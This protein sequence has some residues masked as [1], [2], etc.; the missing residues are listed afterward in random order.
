M[1]KKIGLLFL[2]I[3]YLFFRLFDLE[4]TLNFS[5][6]QGKFLDKTRQIYLSKQIVLIGPPTSIKLKDSREF[7]QGPLTYYLLLPVIALGGDPIYGSYELIFLNLIGLIL[8]F[9]TLE[10]I[11]NTKVA[12]LSGLI[13]ATYPDLVTYT[14]FIWNPN[15]LPFFSSVTLF[16]LEKA[17]NNKSQTI[18]LLIGIVL[19]LALQLH[20][21]V[22]VLI[23]IVLGFFL[24]KKENFYSFISLIAGICIGFFPILIFEVRH[25]FYNFRTVLLIFKSGTGK[26]FSTVPVYFLLVLTPYF[27]LLGGFLFNK[28]FSKTLIIGTGL[29][30]MYL[31]WS[32]ITVNAFSKNPPGMPVGWSYKAEKKVRDIILNND[33]K[34]YNIASLISG[35]T[36]ASDLRYLMTQAGFTPEDVGDYPTSQNLYV[37]SRFDQNKTVK[38]LVWEISSFRPK[39]IDKSWEIQNNIHLYLL[40]K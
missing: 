28:V 38:N 14:T 29:L 7:Y 8:L 6:E 16:L 36:Q 10:K 9:K 19:G 11:F 27:C 22:F 23:F 3:I 18:T 34:D 31:I 25:N 4:S 37:L 40:K 13:W 17:K 32:G 12:F 2:I 15:F 30:F 26:S 35:D 1:F 33:K 5:S 21:Q 20:Y 39:K 24:Y